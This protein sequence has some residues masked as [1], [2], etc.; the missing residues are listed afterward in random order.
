MDTMTEAE[1]ADFFSGEAYTGGAGAVTGWADKGVTVTRVAPGEQ[2]KVW[3]GSELIGFTTESGEFPGRGVY[4]AVL[5]VRDDGTPQSVPFPVGFVPPDPL[6][7][8]R[9]EQERWLP[10]D[11]PAR[12]HREGTTT[13]RKPSVYRVGIGHVYVGGHTNVDI[14][15]LYNQ[16]D[17]KR[18]EIQR[19]PQVGEPRDWQRHTEEVPA[20]VAA[21]LAEV[22]QAVGSLEEVQALAELLQA[23]AD[24]EPDARDGAGFGDED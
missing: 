19:T 2:V 3:H 11:H 15:A 24:Y 16:R 7:A 1:I 8:R 22:L 9:G 5:Y 17:G 20:A 18:V 4:Y 14:G 6:R 21:H 23:A 10:E 13:A 12:H